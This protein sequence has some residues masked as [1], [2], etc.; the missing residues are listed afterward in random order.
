MWDIMPWWGLGH[1]CVS[2]PYTHFNVGFFSFARYEGAAQLTWGF[3]SKE[4]I[5]HIATDSVCLL[6]ISASSCVNIFNWN[7]GFILTYFSH[8]L[9]LICLRICLQFLTVLPLIQICSDFSLLISISFYLIHKEPPRLT[10]F[11]SFFSEESLAHS[12]G[13][14]A[15]LAQVVPRQ[16][17]PSVGSRGWTW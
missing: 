10:E 17:E 3:L 2:A 1:N 7:P 14:P 4:I 11:H 13:K 6:L 15:R 16:R 5:P 9:P 8:L 12:P